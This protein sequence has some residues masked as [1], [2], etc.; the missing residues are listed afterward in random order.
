VD[1]DFLA[2]G[3]GRVLGSTLSWAGFVREHWELILSSTQ[4]QATS[5]ADEGR[6]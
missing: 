4:G 3:A 2:R 1:H 6:Q 5:A